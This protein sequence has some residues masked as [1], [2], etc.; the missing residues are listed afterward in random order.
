MGGSS[1]FCCVFLL[2]VWEV[3]LFVVGATPAGA[4]RPLLFAM[5]NSH[6]F[7]LA[8]LAKYAALF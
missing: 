6:S 2:Y 3:A 1:D 7:R 4:A 8:P 5:H